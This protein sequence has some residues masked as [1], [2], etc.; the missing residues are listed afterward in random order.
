MMLKKRLSSVMLGLTGLLAFEGY[1]VGQEPA[2]KGELRYGAN[3]TLVDWDTRRATNAIFTSLVFERLIGI[4]AKAAELIPHLATE[5][6]LTNTELDLV[7]Q[8]GVSFHDGTPFNAE[9]VVANLNQIKSS[10]NKLAGPFTA[11]SSIEAVDEF[12]VRLTFSR[13]YPLILTNLASLGAEM[14]SPNTLADQSYVT[15][16]VGTGP[17]VYDRASSVAGSEEVFARNGSYWNPDA[18]G[19]SKVTVFSILD[20]SA[21][22]NALASGQVNVIDL[23][24]DL[25]S[26]AER[27]GYKLAPGRLHRPH[28]QFK[29]ARP[30]SP[31]SD[32]RVRQAMCHALDRKGMSAVQ[33]G[34][35][36]TP[37]EQLVP[38]GSPGYSSSVTP[39]PYDPDRARELLKEAGNPKISFTL[40]VYTGVEPMHELIAQN[41][42]AVGIDVKLDQLTRPQYFMSPLK[43]AYPV[44]FNTT[45]SMEV[46][47]AGPTPYY[48]QNLAPTAAYNPFKVTFPQL[49]EIMTAA[50][51]AA[52]ASAEQQAKWEE[53]SNYITKEAITCG[54][55]DTQSNFAYDP[56]VVEFVEAQ[57]YSP[58]QIIYNT[59]RVKE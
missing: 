56:Q 13:P 22:F 37:E 16:P 44:Y 15:N 58:L 1:A 5:W 35:F 47:L 59:A 42:R 48:Q 49:D 6:T 12:H 4:K 32:L 40:P 7:L 9:A 14:I 30:E 50:S 39:Y 24:S 29:D 25:I 34:G 53:A 38:E 33:Y 2:L 55:L 31:F 54:F 52:P 46:W 45:A 11:I 20:A 19:P 43:T 36:A 17:F 23:Q 21:R 57:D 10:P 28:L 18:I 51:K 26:R 3:Q 27:G 8:K 41:L